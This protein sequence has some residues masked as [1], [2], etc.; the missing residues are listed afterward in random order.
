MT[1]DEVQFQTDITKKYLK[2]LEEKQKKFDEKRKQ[3]KIKSVQLKIEYINEHEDIKN[4]LLKSIKHAYKNCND[5]NIINGFYLDKEVRKYN[6]P[7]CAL[8]ELLNNYYTLD[9]DFNFEVYLTLIK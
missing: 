9:F 7:K 6:C 2:Q 3:E 1:E 5:K 4:F 8:I